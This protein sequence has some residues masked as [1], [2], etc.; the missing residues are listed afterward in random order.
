MNHY[1]EGRT[2]SDRCVVKMLSLGTPGHCIVLIRYYGI[3]NGNEWLLRRSHVAWSLCSENA[4]SRF[5]IFHISKSLLS[6]S[7][8]CTD[9][10][11]HQNVHERYVCVLRIVNFLWVCNFHKIGMLVHIS[12]C[13]EN[14][15]SGRPGFLHSRNSLFHC[16]NSNES[17]LRR[18]HAAGSLCSENASTGHTGTLHS[19]DSILLHSQQ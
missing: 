5:M 3:P 10:L 13:S 4:P 18:P 9:T 11:R 1:Y 8:K 19:R 17:L 2:R 7:Q 14:A 12:W 6:G 15:F 16:P